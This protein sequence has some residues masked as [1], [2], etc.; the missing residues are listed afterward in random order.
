MA[1][2]GKSH[3]GMPTRA[4]LSSCRR[5]P[6][7]TAALV[8]VIID[9]EDSFWNILNWSGSYRNL[10]TQMVSIGRLLFMPTGPG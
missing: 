7:A 8:K 3:K 4:P 6:A 5:C 10:A 2:H 1:Q 9:D